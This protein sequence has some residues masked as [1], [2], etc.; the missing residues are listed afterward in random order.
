MENA[1]GD[2]ATHQATELERVNTFMAAAVAKGDLR[3]VAKFCELRAKLLGL[4]GPKVA[5]VAPAVAIDWDAV[6]QAVK[7]VE[8]D[9]IEERLA[10]ASTPALEARLNG[11][12]E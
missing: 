3:L 9:Q 10:A 8:V 2:F 1:R 11:A 4:I 6:Q 5:V 12:K 7:S